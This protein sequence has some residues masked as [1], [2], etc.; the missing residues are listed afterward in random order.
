MNFQHSTGKAP[1]WF[2]ATSPGG[3]PGS[4]DSQG[5]QLQDSP[6]MQIAL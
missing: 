6:A 5:M 2:P 1:S 3:L 4:L